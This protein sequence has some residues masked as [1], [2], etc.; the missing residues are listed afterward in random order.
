MPKKPTWHIRLT[1]RGALLSGFTWIDLGGELIVKPLV[2]SVRKHLSIYPSGGKLH[3]HVAHEE[4][5]SNRRHTQRAEIQP[6]RLLN[7][8]LSAL[9]PA[10]DPPPLI[11]SFDDEGQMSDL[12]AWFGRIWPRLVRKVTNQ[13]VHIV[14]G[15]LG[16]FL[17]SAFTAQMPRDFDL[18][19]EPLVSYYGSVESEEDL[20][21]TIMESDLRLSGQRVAFSEDWSKF[22]V[23]LTDDTVFEPDV[24]RLEAAVEENLRTLGFTGFLRSLR[25]KGYAPIDETGARKMREALPPES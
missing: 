4:Y 3:R 2:G 24:E 6:E 23:L 9:A 20:Y 12:T 19:F 7:P 14:K 1:F 16:G 5:T 8:I 22:L 21:G 25:R 17:N 13:P 11:T 18:D 15:P 10:D